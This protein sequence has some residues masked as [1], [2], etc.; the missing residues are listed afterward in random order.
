[1]SIETNIKLG[2]EQSDN[3][4]VDIVGDEVDEAEK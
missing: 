2:L 4:S 1:M 3:T